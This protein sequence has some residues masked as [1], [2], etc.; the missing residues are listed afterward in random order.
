MRYKGIILPSTRPQCCWAN[1]EGSI[2]GLELE[3]DME[4]E[5]T[6]VS[7][8][9]KLESKKKKTKRPFGSVFFKK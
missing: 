1:W 8:I 5:Q 7:P 4:Q 2:C 6:A 3:A 9:W